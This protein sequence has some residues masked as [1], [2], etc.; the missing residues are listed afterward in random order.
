MWEEER[1][2]QYNGIFVHTV[3]EFIVRRRYFHSEM[4]QKGQDCVEAEQ[5]GI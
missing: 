4:K 1:Q 5:I 3:K 2:L